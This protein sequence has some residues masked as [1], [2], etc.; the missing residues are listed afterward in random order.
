MG[1]HPGEGAKPVFD[2][3]SRIDAISRIRGKNLESH[4][5]W[6]DLG[7]ITGIDKKRPNGIQWCR[8]TLNPQ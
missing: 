4:R 8:N 5:G 2:E 3:L 6:R 1:S 7:K